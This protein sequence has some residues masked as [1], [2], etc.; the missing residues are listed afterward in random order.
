VAAFQKRRRRGVAA[1]LQR[2]VARG[3]Q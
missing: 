1:H 2:D 3:E